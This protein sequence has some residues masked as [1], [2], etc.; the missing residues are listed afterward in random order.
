MFLARIN[1]LYSKTFPLGRYNNSKLFS[2]LSKL[3]DINHTRIAKGSYFDP[4][5][6]NITR[7]LSFRYSASM[8]DKFGL[9]KQKIGRASFRY[10]TRSYF[11]PNHRS[12]KISKHQESLLELKFLFG[13]DN[14]NR[15]TTISLEGWSDLDR[16]LWNWKKL[17]RKKDFP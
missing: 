1:P 4:I 17:I 13:C 7:C 11:K 10:F 6:T 14:N 2:Y 3:G 16:T 5:S 9:I 15:K 12:F 8:Y